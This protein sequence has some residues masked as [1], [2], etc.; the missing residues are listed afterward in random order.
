MSAVVRN[1]A[2]LMSKSRGRRGE[3]GFTLM[4]L[5]VVVIIVGILAVLAIP[6][7]GDARFNRHAYDDAGAIM[8]LFRKARGRAI[9]RGAAELVSMS[10]T[11]AAGK[12]MYFLYEAVQPNPF[13]QGGQA[14][15]PVTTCMP[16]TIWPSAPPAAVGTATVVFVDGI[17]LNGNVE[18][19]ASI[20]STIFDTTGTAQATAALCFTPLGRSY[21]STTSPPTFITGAPLNAANGGALTGALRVDVTRTTGGITRRVVVPPTGAARIISF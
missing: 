16:P 3:G 1:G 9:A 4:E 11:G 15:T 10:T 18:T 21:F 6:A 20:L 2:H 13:S 8:Q 19:Q 12:G 7:M 5:L 17:N 14:F